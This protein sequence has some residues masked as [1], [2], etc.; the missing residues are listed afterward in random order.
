[1]IMWINKFE[2]YPALFKPLLDEVEEEKVWISFYFLNDSVL[3]K[4]F[5]NYDS[6]PQ[7]RHQQH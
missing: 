7:P 6:V 4:D 3:R 2:T 5:I 1:M